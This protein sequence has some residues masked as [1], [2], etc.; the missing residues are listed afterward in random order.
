M[1]FQNDYDIYQFATSNNETNLFLSTNQLLT[2][3]ETNEDYTKKIL[4]TTKKKK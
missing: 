2:N 1:N 4:N 3:Y